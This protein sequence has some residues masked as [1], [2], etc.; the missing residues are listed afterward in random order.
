MTASNN[1]S[2]S[3]GSSSQTIPAHFDPEEIED[4]SNP[5]PRPLF[6]VPL[7][8]LACQHAPANSKVDILAYGG[9]DGCIYLINNHGGDGSNSK[10][11]VIRKY[12]D[13][14]KAIAVSP[15]GL[16]VSI[17]FDDGS[18]KIFSY[19]DFVPADGGDDDSDD[20]NIAVHHPFIP[21]KSLTANDDGEGFLSQA[22]DG[23]SQDDTANAAVEFDGPRMD[24]AI[25]QMAF[26]PRSSA[27]GGSGIG[28]YYLAIVSESGNQPLAIVDA[29][30]DSTIET[31]YL[32]E[33]SADEHDAGGVRSVAY[34]VGSQA[35][36]DNVLLATLG[37]DG[38]LV[39]WDVSSSNDPSL[40]W[41]VCHKDYSAVVPK[42]D[43]GEMGGDAGD[44]GC[45]VLWSNS[46]GVKDGASAVLF[47]PGQTDIQYRLCPLSKSK[48]GGSDEAL[49]TEECKGHLKGPPK[50][51]VDEGGNGHKDTIVAMAVMPQQHPNTRIVTGGRDGK[52]LLW[53]LNLEEN[54]GGAQEIPLQRSATTFGIPPITSI[55][56]RRAEELHVAFADG[57]VMMVPVPE[58]VE[59][60][61]QELDED[62]DGLATQPVDKDVEEEEKA[63]RKS[64]M[65]SV[66]DD[67]DDDGMFDEDA[68]ASSTAPSKKNDTQK[69]AAKEIASS[70]KTRFIDDEAEDGDDDDIQYDDA[71]KT[72]D[73]DAQ[74]NANAEQST[75]QDNANAADEDVDE[76]MFN[77]DDLDITDTPATA[78]NYN[79]LPP[80]QPAF[81]PSSTPLGEPRRILCWNHVGVVTLRSDTSNEGTDS[82]NNL[83]DIAFHETAGLV[84]GRRPF[85]FTDNVGFIVGTLGEEGGMFASDLIEDEDDEEDDLDDDFAGISE[86]TRKAIQRDKRQKKSASAKGSQVYFRRFETFGKMADKDW[87]VALPDGERAVGCATGGGWG[88]VITSRRFL[89]LFTISGIQ[90]PVHWIPGEP[91]TVVGRDRFVAVFYHRSVSPMQDGTQLLGYS[92]MDGVTGAIVATGEVSALSAG[93]SLSWAGFTDKSAL[94]IMDS[95]GML[96]MLARYSNNNAPA[97]NN[98]NWMPMLDTVG[99]K[100]TMN[101]TFWPVEVHGGKLVCVPLRGGK[102]HPDAARR[103]VT[104]TLNLRIPL[105]TSLTV[106][107]GPLEESSV[108]AIF[109]LNQE[110]VL[111]DYLV[112]QGDANEDEIEEE[113]N[114]K[115]LNVD[116]VTLKLF[117]SVVESGKVERGFDLVQRLHSEQTY[118][119]AIQMADRVGHR[120][121]S[122]RIEEVKLQKFPPLEEEEEPFND[123]ASFE[124]GMRSE[125]SNSF[126]EYEPVVTTRQQRMEMMNRGISPEGEGAHSPQ[127]RR[128]HDD[129]AEES[130]RG[131]NST[132]AES[133]P[134]ESLKRKF[135]QDHH[136]TPAASNKKRINPFARKLMES[137]AK[138]IMKV[139]GSPTKLS[140]SRA[141][142]F[143]TKSRQKQRSGKQIV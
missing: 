23:L 124:S 93:A 131:Y 55:V 57:T 114:Q 81:A 35:E 61:S 17:G 94:S 51:I 56:W 119:I 62:V 110:K 109:A 135:E 77:Y 43:A 74:D 63:P 82:N 99:L 7:P 98:G 115:C 20:N 86:A 8:P 6:L 34:T 80:L 100:K 65:A 126:D 66:D 24:A 25:R 107:S 22:N 79:N 108:R 104:T 36:G 50:F 113:Y 88:A 40:M 72:T 11:R 4:S 5:Y 15:D 122:D 97:S 46:M 19:N 83:V 2:S 49:T 133:P 10:P 39:T 42:K 64:K 54:T 59:E 95:D 139:V 85:T 21:P 58:A 53:Q 116:K 60:V 136:A 37:M 29:T 137:P 105:A 75:A 69:P 141:S 140:L 143:S 41:D 27:K 67:S 129:D 73:N 76:D 70:K 96:S 128:S 130:E 9:D 103:P 26:D 31:L 101:D 125:R 45:R 90:G 52:L 120:K 44:K 3:G 38:K 12:D 118:D 16:R 33:K 91:V 14:V 127:R 123:S 18:T 30:D 138:G 134:R 47:L 117:R 111:D 32:D 84:G 13:E 87:V 121:L 142:T 102:E 89:R 112:S 132:D 1:A 92:I 106:K 28:K 68:T 71:I 48:K 78:A